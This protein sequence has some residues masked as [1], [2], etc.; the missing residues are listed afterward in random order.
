MKYLP[1][2]IEKMYKEKSLHDLGFFA[3]TNALDWSQQG[4]DDLVLEP[5]IQYLSQWPDEVI[6]Y[7]RTRWQNFCMDWTGQR[8]PG[9]PTGRINIFPETVSSMP[10]AWRW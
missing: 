3:M 9:A 1:P 7:L 6:L 2:V 8:L 4:N 10:G 5:L